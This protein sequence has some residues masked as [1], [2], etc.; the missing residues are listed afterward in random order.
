VK[1]RNRL[2]PTTDSTL[3]GLDPS[4]ERELACLGRSDEDFQSRAFQT[5][6]ASGRERALAQL[7]SVSRERPCDDANGK[8]TFALTV[9]FR[10]LSM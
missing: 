7:S 3:S 9:P 2:I 6:V 1:V 5:F 10:G 8:K 4:G